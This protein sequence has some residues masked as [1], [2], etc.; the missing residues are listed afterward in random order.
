MK[1]K[2]YIQDN[3]VSE[4]EALDTDDAIRVVLSKIYNGDIVYDKSE[5]MN[6]KLEPVNE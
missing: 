1:Y 4:V 5:S 2:V 3:F 6:L